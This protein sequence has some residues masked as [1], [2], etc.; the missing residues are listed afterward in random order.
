VITLELLQKLCPQTPGGRLAMFVEPLNYTV[1]D[2]NITRV[3]NFLAQVAHESGGF[4]YTT[5]LWGPTGPQS[6]YDARADLGNT[7]P[8]AIRIAAV[9]GDKPGHFWR[10]RGLIQTTGYNNFRRVRD[11]L[12]IDCVNHPEF[13]AAPL[14][15]AESAGVFWQ[16]NGCDGID[17]FEKL[18]RKINGGLNGLAD[19]KAYLARIA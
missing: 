5:E 8:E 9:Y 12:G 2:Y 16:D 15:A 10:G 4:V 14:H 17:D 3:A 13:L 11:R 18:T 1:N 19:R 7:D 6:R